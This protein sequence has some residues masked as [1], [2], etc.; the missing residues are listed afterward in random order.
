[1]NLA[2]ALPEEPAQSAPLEG[3][4]W[5]AALAMLIVLFAPY[6]TLVQTVLT[7][8]AVRKGIEADDYDMT[9][10]TVGYG[11]GI[12]YGLF[13]A[14]WLS[15]RIG[16]R[17]TIMLGLAGFALGN[18]LCGA[19]GSL[20]GFVVGRFVDGFGKMLVMGLARATLYKQFDRVVL[21]AVGFYGVFAYST[22]H[23]TPL[24]M[25]ELE[26]WL[27]WRWMYWFYIPVALAALG[28]VWVY[29]RP[30]VPAKPFNLPIDWFAVTLF[31][32]WVVAVTFAFSWYRKWGGWSSNEFAFTVVLCVA[33]PVVLVAWVASGFSPDEHLMRLLRTRIYVLSV[34]TRGF[35]LLQLVA[36]LTLVGMYATE[37][38]G[39]PRT[40]AGWLMV[41][42][43]LTMAST[44]ALTTWF[45]WR[46]LRHVW[47]V[48]AV[49]GTSACMWWLSS[50]NN[51][52][53][54][55]EIALIL[56][57]W[58]AFV[59]LIPPVFLTDEIEGLNPKD[60][61][62]AGALAVV[63]LVVPIITIPSATGTVVKVW[64]DRAVDT[65]RLNLRTNSPAVSEAGGRVADYFQQRGLSGPELQQET[66]RVLGGFATVES[67]AVGFRWGLRFLSLMTLAVGLVVSVLLWQAAQ[68]LRAPPGSGYD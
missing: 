5:L 49:V 18:L 38:R 54:K 31:T 39:Y 21:V 26:T 42:T 25:A 4:H 13:T 40:T 11:V 24:L 61:L 43:A 62:Y 41:P 65:Y 64:S 45:H 63:G 17:Y 48:V 1:M 10:A 6:Q 51:F 47:L 29:F 22:R 20:V 28:L 12:L 53:P 15:F 67:I 3:R 56:A 2:P 32:A 37:L 50:L 66:G 30:D 19:A 8:D 36:V 55:E 60:G 7:D 14:L 57:C 46:P 35:M 52:T 33:L 23:C 34:T 9:W 68:G 59:G 44:T 58:G 27:S 16:S